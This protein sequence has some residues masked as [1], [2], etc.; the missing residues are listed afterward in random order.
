MNLGLNADDL[1]KCVQ[2]GLCIPS[3]PT[4]R[5][6]G[7]EAMSPRGRIALMRQVQNEGAPVTPEIISSMDT[8]IQ[9]RGCEPACPSA[10]P[11]GRLIEQTR[12]SLAQSHLITPRW[13]RLALNALKHPSVMRA[14]TTAF[15]LAQRVRLVPKRLDPGI[16]AP[17][18][19]PPMHPSGKDVYLFTGCVMDAWQRDIHR[20]TKRVLEAAGF[21]VTPTGDSTGCCGALHSH[22]GLGHQA[23]DLARHVIETLSL[24]G[25]DTPIVVNSAGCG[26]ALKEYGHVLAT[27][28]AEQ[29]SARVLD[30]SEFLAENLDRLPSATPLNLRVAIQDPCH[31][32]HVQ[33]SHEATRV[34]LEPHVETLLEIDDDAMC[35]GA[36]G[37]FSII[38]PELSQLVRDRKVASINRLTFDYVASANPGCLL[39]LA[40][41]GVK[42]IHPITLVDWA[43]GNRPQR[44]EP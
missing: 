1:N 42:T 28:E 37:A 4:F 31:L 44:D 34:V 18:A 20:S 23:R 24:D 41:A 7:D 22:G 38:Q 30:I 19:N 12:Q 40:D 32:R 35:C 5:V 43:L 17:F 13:F 29:F 33:K 25:T 6:T 36:G 14:S 27:P 10:V 39:H 16:Q 21:G 26:A 11:Y 2:C 8:C 3:C 15:A 9:C